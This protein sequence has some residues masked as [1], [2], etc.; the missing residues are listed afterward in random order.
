MEPK[1][2]TKQEAQ[3]MV[4]Q[5][6]VAFKEKNLSFRS[7]VRMDRPRDS[8]TLGSFKKTTITGSRGGN[9]ALANLLTALAAQGLIT[10]STS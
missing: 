8:R 1:T 6:L 7:F 10:D 2:L 5:A 9:A 3:K 4:D